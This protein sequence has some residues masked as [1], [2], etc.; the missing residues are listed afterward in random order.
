VTPTR[1][2]SNKTQIAYR[3]TVLTY[4][5]T[6][7]R[8]RGLDQWY[9]THVSLTHHHVA[10]VRMTHA[11]VVAVPLPDISSSLI[12][13]NSDWRRLPSEGTVA[14]LQAHKCVNVCDEGAVK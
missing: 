6:P 5:S 8:L 9:M 4:L 7:H 12:C 1:Y 3:Y 2:H 13:A 10:A 11:R 14:T